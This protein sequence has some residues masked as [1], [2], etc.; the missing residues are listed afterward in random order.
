MS[1]I[2]F[3]LNKAQQ[4]AITS[5]DRELNFPQLVPQQ[6]DILDGSTLGGTKAIYA[7]TRNTTLD[8]I[9]KL[10]LVQVIF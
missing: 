6:I 1:R 5:P 8:T 3:K 4:I 10:A 9:R 7:Q 2:F